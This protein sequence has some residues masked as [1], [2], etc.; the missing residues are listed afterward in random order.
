MFV[1]STERV[2][3]RHPFL[4][5]VVLAFRRFEGEE[6]D[7][8]DKER[9]KLAGRK[10]F[11]E[12]FKLLL[13]QVAAR[14]CVEWEGVTDRNGKP[15]ECNDT[16]KAAF[17]AHPEAEKYWWNQIFTYLHPGKLDTDEAKELE[18]AED[19]DFFGSRSSST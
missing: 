4:D 8:Y 11:A 14:L 17:F 5:G 15:L 12:K 9:S 13:Q 1:L 7:I 10:G 18:E 6:R 2:V 16:N 19:P 3:T